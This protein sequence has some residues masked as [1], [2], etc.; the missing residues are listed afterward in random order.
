[1]INRKSATIKKR[2]LND[3][4]DLDRYPIHDLDNKHG[5]AL[6]AEVAEHIAQH[7]LEYWHQLLDTVDC[8]YVP[9]FGPQNPQVG[10]VTVTR[11]LSVKGCLVVKRG[12]LVEY[13][14]LLLILQCL[15]RDFLV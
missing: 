13:L 15:F 2:R 14:G 3:C 4:I 12:T 7:P 1:M 6:I 11:K 5:Q 10:C 9:L 8:C